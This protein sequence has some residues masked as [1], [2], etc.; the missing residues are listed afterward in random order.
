MPNA[1]ARLAPT[2]EHDQGA[3]DGE[4]DLRFDDGGIAWRRGRAARSQRER[5]AERRRERKSDS[6]LRESRAQVADQLA[7]FAATGSLPTERAGLLCG[8]R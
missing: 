4:H 3:D 1:R 8:R 7:G 6:R 5:G 2:I